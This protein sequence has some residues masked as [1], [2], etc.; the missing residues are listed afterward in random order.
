MSPI[1]V[2]EGKGDKDRVM[3]LPRAVHPDLFDHLLREQGKRGQR[4]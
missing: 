2:R 1:V 3:I 4:E